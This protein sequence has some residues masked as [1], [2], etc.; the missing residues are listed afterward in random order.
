[1]STSFHLAQINIGKMLG[2]IDGPVMAEFINN[3][4]RIN[5]MAE[6]SEGFIWRL[7]ADDNNA[8]SIKMFDDELIIINMSVWKDIDALF[9]FAYQTG[10]AEYVKRRREWF[11]K[12]REAYMALWYVPAGHKPTPQ[13]AVERLNHLRQHGETPYAFTFKKR[14]T[15]TDVE[16]YIVA[17]AAN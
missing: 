1:M 7:K 11:E 5:A 6:G 15:I 3:L 17:S 12:M 13:E 16:Q 10:H 14:F 4:D 9:A 8:T 2:P